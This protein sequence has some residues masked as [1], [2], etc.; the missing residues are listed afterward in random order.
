[1]YIPIHVQD[2]EKKKRE[3]LLEEEEMRKTEFL[4]VMH[5]LRLIIICI[6]WFP[7]TRFIHFDPC[8]GGSNGRIIWNI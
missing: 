8:G 1:M 6:E 5:G 7:F 4:E 2:E 3:E